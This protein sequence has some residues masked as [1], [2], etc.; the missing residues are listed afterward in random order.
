MTQAQEAGKRAAGEAALQYVPDGALVGLGTGS[1]VK[2]FLLALGEKVKSGFRVQGIP[3]SQETARLANDLKIPLLP[4]EGDW[5]LDLAV[6]GADQ[7]DPQFQLI[8][9]GG[10][11]LLREKIVASA[12]RQFIVIADEAKWVPVLGMP[13]PVPVEVIPFGWPNA[14]RRIQA[15]G[16]SSSLRKKNNEVFKTDEGNVILDVEVNRIEDPII[17]ETQLN[18]IPGVVENGLFVNRASI[19]ILGSTDGIHIKKRLID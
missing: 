7:V 1:T 6:D 11:A 15:L 12:A 16:W 3:T 4:N 2:Y 5:E 8:K 18:G 13:M 14:Q 9:G 17:L 10:G 19:V